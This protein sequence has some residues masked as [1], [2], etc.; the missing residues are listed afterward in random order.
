MKLYIARIFLKI[1]NWSKKEI[2]SNQLRCMPKVHGSVVAGLDTVF[3]GCILNVQIGAYTYIN[4]AHIEVG[5]EEDGA[6][7]II[8]KGCAI[9]YRVSI[10]ARTHALDK[11]TVNEMGSISH[12][13]KDIV[14][15]DDVWIG[16][17]VYIREGVEIGSNCVIGA[18]SV[19]TK[20][21]PDNAVIAGVP[22]KVI[23]M[24][25]S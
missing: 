25:S 11:P 2:V 13:E 7:V 17:G 3:T 20:S 14:I 8:G 6:K 10:K 21:F 4:Q 22:A 5:C 16:D 12:I 1:Y 24:K 23:K 18:N 15:G 9:G 19:V